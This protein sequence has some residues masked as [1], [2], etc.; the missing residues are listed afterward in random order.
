MFIKNIMK[1]RPTKYE[2]IGSVR[3][4]VQK[5][6]FDRVRVQK[7]VDRSGPGPEILGPDGLYAAEFVRVAQGRREGVRAGGGYRS[8]T[9]TGQKIF[10]GSNIHRLF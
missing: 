4:R 10:A 2:I 5:N 9:E 1:S 6:L 3:V 8:K 7:K